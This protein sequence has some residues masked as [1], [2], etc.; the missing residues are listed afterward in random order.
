MLAL[1]LCVLANVLIMICFKL[2][3]RKKVDSFI[4]IVVNYWVCLILGSVFV[5]HVPILEYGLETKWVPYGLAL[6]VLFISGFNIAA[7]SVNYTGIT[8]TSVMQKMSLLVS[9]AFAIVFFAESTGFFKLLGIALSVLAVILIN[10]TKSEGK[11]FVPGKYFLYPLFTLLFSGVIEIILY[12]VQVT[13]LSLDADAELT[14][15]GFSVAAIIG[16]FIVS[17][18]YATGKKKFQ[19]RDYIGGIA[20]GIPNFFSIY[21]ILVLLQQG[22]EG[23]VVFPVLNISVLIAAAVVGLIAFRE[24]LR[25]VNIVGIIVAILAIVSIMLF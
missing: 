17:Y 7:L 25:P 20:L 3:F 18:Q 21:L 19:K 6:G 22:F 15:F 4:A 10:A 23:S 16:F 5:G 24:K 12:Y 11:G 8:I 9:S 13:G 2:F 1:L 14:T